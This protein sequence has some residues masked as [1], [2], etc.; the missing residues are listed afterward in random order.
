MA[1]SS[2]FNPHPRVSFANASPTGAATEAEYLEIGLARGVDPDAVRA[3]LDAALPE[4]LDILEVV[5]AAGRHGRPAHRLDWEIRRRR[6]AARRCS[7]RRWPPCW[8]PNPSRSS[9]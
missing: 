7:S 3:A 5:E 1:Y 9:A 2:G 4:G 6:A 8:R